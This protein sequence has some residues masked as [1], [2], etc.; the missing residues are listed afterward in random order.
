MTP[1]EIDSI[2]RK[3]SCIATDDLGEAYARLLDDKTTRYRVEETYSYDNESMR[4]YYL[5]NLE[6]AMKF[7]IYTL[8]DIKHDFNI[9]L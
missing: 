4:K 5:S 3:L 9:V 2:I 6:E 8:E 1:F 7:G